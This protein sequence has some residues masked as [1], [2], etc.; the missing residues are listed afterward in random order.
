MRLFLPVRRATL[1]I[2]SGPQGDPN[3]DHLHVLLTDPVGAERLLL[4]A[5][6]CSVKPGIPHDAT[7]YLYPGDHEFVRRQS[8]VFYAQA[9]IVP[10]QKLLSGI[11]SGDFRGQ[12]ALSDALMARIC[13]GLL[14]SRHTKPAIKTFYL[15]TQGQHP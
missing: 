1:T 13:Q 6:V 15:S 9:I 14:D 12:E 3:R 8:Y 2:P 10:E 4:L 5:S 11:R 7:C